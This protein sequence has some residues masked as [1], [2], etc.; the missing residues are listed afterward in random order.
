MKL[1]TKIILPIIL[2]SALLI[3][4]AGCFGV[5]SDEGLGY[6]TGNIMVPSSCLECQTGVCIVKSNGEVPDDWVP[7]EGAV[8]TVIPHAI[9]TDENGNYTLYDIEPGYYYVITATIGSLV[10]KD[11]V[12]TPGVEKDELYY[13]GTAN[14]ESTALGLIVEVLLDMGLDTEDI[15]SALVMI[16]LNPL[17]NDLVDLVCDIIEECGNVT[18]YCEITELIEDIINDEPGFTCPPLDSSLEI[19]IDS[20]NPCLNDCATISSV[21]VSYTDGTTEPLIISPSYTESTPG[22]N[23][24]VDS[25]ISFDP[26]DGTVCLDV[27]GGGVAGKN[28]HI[29]FTYTD[30]CG[31]TA[32][33]TVTVNFVAEYCILICCPPLNQSLTIAINNENPCLGDCATIDSV[34]VSY[35]D[36]ITPDLVIESPYSGKGLSWVVDSGIS[37]NPLNG[38]VCGGG[39]GTTYEIIFTYKDE[40]GM[41]ATGVSTINF[42]DCEEECPLPTDVNAGGPYSDTVTCPDTEATI[43]FVGSASG[44]GTLTYDW[45]FGDDSTPH[46]TGSSPSHTYTYPFNSPYTVTLT[47]N[48]DCGSVEV[49]TTVNIDYEPCEPCISTDLSFFSLEVKEGS[50]WTEYL[51]SVYPFNPSTTVYHV[52]TTNFAEHFRFTVDAACEGEASLSYNWFRGESC[53]NDWIT[54]E[55]GYLNRTE[56]IEIDSGGTYPTAQKDRPVCNKGGNVLLIKVTNG[57]NSNTYKVYVDRP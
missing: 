15:E 22:L 27:D 51:G 49:T 18:N 55:I 35:T 3:L 47:V 26:V 8:V 24:E 19:A 21:T 33:G 23:W 9:K 12:E 31:E 54:G 40:C 20:T 25:G 11:I 4:L 36:G 29:T 42:E 37:F 17:F 38:K 57:E 50:S 14:C 7:A 52:T 34:T 1:S 5:P 53:T 43:D 46:G 45:D 48:D 2:I 16:K 6:I 44:T 10:L 39:V 28:Y 13:A 41:T 30:E 56:W 32:T